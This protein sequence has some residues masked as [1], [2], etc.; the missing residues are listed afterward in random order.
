MPVLLLL[1]TDP[2]I[3]ALDDIYIMISSHHSIQRSLG[4]KDK[5]EVPS[6]KVQST[7]FYIIGCWEQKHELFG[8]KLTSQ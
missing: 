4:E 8:V 1:V 6:I 5:L 7:N 2:P 3:T